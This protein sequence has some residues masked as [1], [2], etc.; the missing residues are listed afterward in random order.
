MQVALCCSQEQ[1]HTQEFIRN[2]VPAECIIDCDAVPS[3]RV[4]PA[5]GEL[6]HIVLK[7]ISDITLFYNIQCF[8]AVGWDPARKGL[9]STQP[10]S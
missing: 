1:I 9:N 7:L 6:M 5:V 3:P 4:L 10:E 2:V 8:D